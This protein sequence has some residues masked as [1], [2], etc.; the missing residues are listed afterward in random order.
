MISKAILILS[1]VNPPLT[2]LDYELYDDDAYCLAVA[3]E[4]TKS[5]EAFNRG[6][7]VYGVITKCVKV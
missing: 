4:I 5:N 1:I 7:K 2:T 3:E 6:E